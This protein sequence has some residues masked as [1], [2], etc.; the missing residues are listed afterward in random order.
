MGGCAPF[1]GADRLAKGKTG[2]LY[3][4]RKPDHA[5][6]HQI[7]IK[8]STGMTTLDWSDDQQSAL[9]S[10]RR[11]RRTAGRGSVHRVF[12]FAGTGKTTLIKALAAGGK[13]CLVSTP[14]GSET[15]HEIAVVSFT[16]KAAQVLRAKGVGQA[17]T[18]HRMIYQTAYE[19][20]VRLQALEV[21]RRNETDRVRR[22]KLD[23]EIA[24]LKASL[25]Q[26][27]FVRDD[28]AFRWIGE[29]ELI[30]ID[31]VSMINEE[32]AEDLLWFGIPLLVFGDPM[33]LPPVKGN[34]YFMD[35][36]PDV[37]MMQIHRQAEGNPII[38]LATAVRE[39]RALAFGD[40]GESEVTKKFPM[41][42]WRDF[43]QL[44]VGQNAEREFRNRQ[45]RKGLGYNS[46]LP[47]TNDRLICLR[48]DHE[49]GLL[50]GSL[51]RVEDTVVE[52]DEFQGD[53]MRVMLVSEDN[54]DQHV[55]C[56]VWK[57][58]FT[59]GYKRF[60]KTHWH[61]GQ[62]QMADE[63]D[64]AY[65]LTVHKAQGSEWKNVLLKDE[66]FLWKRDGTNLNWLYTGITRASERLTLVRR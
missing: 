8:R 19:R 23:R 44:L 59:D 10:I 12:G 42:W 54:A 41:E 35:D 51:W 33:Q 18:I 21:E 5:T 31:E 48:N 13:S 6:H 47:Q 15:Y 37:L 1:G 45:A 16:G 30:I 11:W 43:D 53:L 28:H 20:E 64:F 61:Y 66:S 17:S 26:P 27:S 52:S 32:L 34:S 38:Q 46:P 56:E 65:A 2:R 22:I 60:E 9:E 3:F 4:N 25:R 39:G 29:P 62:R 63:F 7:G 50:N 24:A 49:L 58:I 40:Y 14:W 55:T 57:E 36:E